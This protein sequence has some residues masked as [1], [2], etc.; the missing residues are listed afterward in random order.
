MLILSTS[1]L[2]FPSVSAIE[3]N[4]VSTGMDVNIL[5]TLI[6]IFFVLSTLDQFSEERGNEWGDYL[7]H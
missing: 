1:V 4:G 6:Y 5:D 2:H 7:T 3:N